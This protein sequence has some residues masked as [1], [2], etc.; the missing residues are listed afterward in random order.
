MS[1]FVRVLTALTSLGV[2]LPPLRTAVGGDGVSLHPGSHGG[3]REWHTRLQAVLRYGH[4][5]G[6]TDAHVSR[7]ARPPV[8]VNVNVNANVNDLRLGFSTTTRNPEGILSHNS[9][10][11]LRHY[12]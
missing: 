5:D 8:L 3:G 7:L 11:S 1:G 6:I 10:K 4:P 12:H 2:F 9:R